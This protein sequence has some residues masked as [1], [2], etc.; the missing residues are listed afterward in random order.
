MPEASARPIQSCNT[1]AAVSL[2]GCRQSCRRTLSGNRL[3]PGA[4]SAAAPSPAA[5]APSSWAQVLRALQ[6][7]LRY[8]VCGLPVQAPAEVAPLLVE[9]LV[10]V[11][12]LE[13]GDGAPPNAP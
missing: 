6:Q 4:G 1:F 7:R 8:L 12:V 11:A 3:W 5:P 10:D 2:S 9:P 13:H